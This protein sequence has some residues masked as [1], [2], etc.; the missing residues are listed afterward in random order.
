MIVSRPTEASGLIAVRGKAD[1]IGAGF[2]DFVR[3]T[4]M[5]GVGSGGRS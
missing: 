1:G 4:E 3:I 2:Q 5:V